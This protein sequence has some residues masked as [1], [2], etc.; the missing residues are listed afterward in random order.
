MPWSPL[1]RASL[2][3]LLSCALTTFS[4]VLGAGKHQACQEKGGTDLAQCPKGT[5]VVHNSTELTAALAGTAPVILISQRDIESSGY[6]NFDA[7]YAVKRSV[8]LLGEL[9]WTEEAGKAARFTWPVIHAAPTDETPVFSFD[10]QGKT[11]AIHDVEVWNQR[12]TE[13]INATP[14]KRD[15]PTGQSNANG[16][17]TG[18]PTS[19]P[20]ANANA[21]PNADGKTDG[22]TSTNANGNATPNADGKTDGKTSTNA[23]GNAGLNADGKTNANAGGDP[24]ASKAITA[25]NTAPNTSSNGNKPAPGAALTD[26]P[27][28]KGAAPSANA[29]L[30]HIGP[31]F[32]VAQ[33]TKVLFSNTWAIAWR[34][35]VRCDGECFWLAGLVAGWQDT[36]VGSGKMFMWQPMIS[37]RRAGTIAA[38]SGNRGGALAVNQ[39]MI[40]GEG[41]A[42]SVIGKGTVPAAR[43]WDSMARTAFLDSEYMDDSL[44]PKMWN[45]KGVSTSFVVGKTQFY[46]L[47]MFGV[48]FNETLVDWTMDGTNW[49]LQNKK[50]GILYY[51]DRARF[52]GSDWPKQDPVADIGEEEWAEVDDKCYWRTVQNVKYWANKK[53]P[54][55]CPAS[56]K[57]ATSV[58]PAVKAS[59]PTKAKRSVK[60]P[61]GSYI[62]TTK[63]T[64]L[65][66]GTRPLKVLHKHTHHRR[67]IEEHKP[68]FQRRRATSQSTPA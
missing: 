12:D 64:Q 3:L 58:K 20:N 7:K 27:G 43:P 24:N 6:V 65:S 38:W 54:W 22:K 26:K 5:V 49:L 59:S 30:P 11:I 19:T 29:D 10:A 23:G 33:G 9:I 45:S 40:G 34:H 66:K 21:T 55:T 52:F 47:G 42:E 32:F 41:G 31:S 8:T 4:G 18:E 35:T 62:H 13:A 17:P 16:A 46:H 68:A 67:S 15:L 44:D 50:G 37:A 61:K 51:Q 28:E 39:A 60:P 63:L 56:S 2:L 48:G 1:H 14:V 57:G 25:P 36:L 53:A